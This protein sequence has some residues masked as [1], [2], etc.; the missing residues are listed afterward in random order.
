MHGLVQIP[1]PQCKRHPRFNFGTFWNPFM[2][3]GAPK[4]A[5]LLGESASHFTPDFGAQWCQISGWAERLWDHLHDLNHRAIEC[6]SSKVSVQALAEWLG[7]KAQPGLCGI[8]SLGCLGYVYLIFQLWTLGF[9]G[10]IKIQF[11]CI[12]CSFSSAFSSIVLLVAG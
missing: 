6:S 5:C 2:S 12:L 4:V 7:A 9:F 11:W 8:Q 1:F 3:S 10:C